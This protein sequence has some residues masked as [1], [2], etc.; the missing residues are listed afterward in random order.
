MTVEDDASTRVAAAR[1]ERP[2]SFHGLPATDARG[3]GGATS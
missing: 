1:C 2:A 3:D